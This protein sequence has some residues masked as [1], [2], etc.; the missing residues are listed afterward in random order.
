MHKQPLPEWCADFMQK[1]MDEQLD[2]PKREGRR[3]VNEID[4]AIDESRLSGYHLRRTLLTAT[5]EQRMR[6]LH[7]YFHVIPWALCVHAC[8][9]AC[10]RACV[11]ACVCACVCMCVVGGGILEGGLLHELHAAICSAYAT[12]LHG[13][14]GFIPNT[15]VYGLFILLCKL[16]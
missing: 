8:V 2:A 4:K 6:M 3:M 15:P 7:H 16:V 11:R 10:E 5:H 14:P 12:H 9:R 13:F 1:V